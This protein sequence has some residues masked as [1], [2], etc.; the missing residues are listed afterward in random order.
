MKKHIKLS[1]IRNK[2]FV[3]KNSLDNKNLDDNL[4]NLDNFAEI[5]KNFDKEQLI[6]EPDLIIKK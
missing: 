1:Q 5:N 3:K 2:V 4:Y 6:D